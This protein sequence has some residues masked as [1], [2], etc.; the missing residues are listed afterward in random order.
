MMLA[1]PLPSPSLLST[2]QEAPPQL[3]AASPITAIPPLAQPLPSP[4]PPRYLA[5]PAFLDTLRLLNLAQPPSDT[6]S[7]W[8]GIDGILRL[9]ADNPLESL[10]DTDP[11]LWLSLL[12]NAPTPQREAFDRLWE[13]RLLRALLALPRPWEQ[14]PEA[15]AAL[16]THRLAAWSL[17]P[18][19][20]D[21]QTLAAMQT[22]PERLLPRAE[23][24][25]TQ[26]WQPFLL[27]HLS[28][29]K[30]TYFAHP[31][32]LP[33][34][35]HTFASGRLDLLWQD[36]QDRWHLWAWSFL[37]PDPALLPRYQETLALQARAV[38]D[39]LSLNPHTA[40]LSND[41]STLVQNSV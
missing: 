30:H 14:T 33:Q 10:V 32:S 36:A 37:P 16:W 11:L 2:R 15:R 3:L 5:S 18:A 26:C 23:A 13:M 35:H 31:F 8:Q 27:Q 29:A 7:A 20:Y 41:H 9:C 19:Q 25:W 1:R 40:L 17:S 24:L 6:A 28:H 22:Q 12:P 21:P 4:A 34:P 39:A 38:Q